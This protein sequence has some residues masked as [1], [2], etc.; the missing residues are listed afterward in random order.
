MSLPFALL[1]P[2][3]ETLSDPPRRR[4]LS[5]SQS[6]HLE[7]II[8]AANLHAFN[9]G[10]KG[11]SSPSVFKKVLATVDVPAFVPKQGVKVQVNDAEPV[12]NEEEGAFQSCPQ[13]GVSDD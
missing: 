12:A 11:E 8:S 4:H 13:L 1:L 5:L 3:R 7:Y 2:P 9:Y 6:I 10:L